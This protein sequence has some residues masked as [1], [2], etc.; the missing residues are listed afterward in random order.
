M[1]LAQ[2]LLPVALTA[3]LAV[4]HAQPEQSGFGWPSDLNATRHAAIQQ[5]KPILLLVYRDGCPAC[6]DIIA[7][8]SGNKFLQEQIKRFAYVALSVDEASAQGFTASRTP[9][10]LFLSPQGQNI[11]APLQGAPKDDFEFVDYLTGVELMFN[12]R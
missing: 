2:K 11:V 8:I 1:K 6:E 10:F 12:Q 3:L 9:T 7:R 4:A 5:H